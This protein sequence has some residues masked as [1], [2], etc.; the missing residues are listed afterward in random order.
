[1]PGLTI[2]VVD[3]D[4]DYLGIEIRACSDRFAGS[5]RIYAGLD[6]LSAFA[7][8]LTGFPEG[9]DDRR[10]YEF[11]SR[12]PSMAGGYCGLLLRCVD[13]AGHVAVAVTID[14]DGDRYA[15]ASAQM[16]FPTEAAAIDT[17]IA[18]LREIQFKKSGVA[19]LC[20]VVAIG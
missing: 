17:F 10:T 7:D 15:P 2:S 20:S 6:E 18:S 16:S 13:Q 1:M 12:E 19:L 3:P 5:A 14:D 4:D 11:G 8:R 9:N